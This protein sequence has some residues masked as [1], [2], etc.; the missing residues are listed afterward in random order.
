MPAFIARATA[1]VN[2]AASKGEIINRSTPWVTKLSTCEV[3]V[4]SLPAAVG[5]LA[6]RMRIALAS[7]IRSLLTC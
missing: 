4:L 6:I 3:C 5:D 2:G 7:S 1:G